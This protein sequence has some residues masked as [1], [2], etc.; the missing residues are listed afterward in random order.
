MSAT[1]FVSLIGAHVTLLWAVDQPRAI[2]AVAPARV[3]AVIASC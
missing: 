3:D 1:G 2:G